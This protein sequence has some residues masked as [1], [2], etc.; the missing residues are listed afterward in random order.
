MAGNLLQPIGQ[1][2]VRKKKLPARF[3]RLTRVATVV[4]APTAA[5][6]AKALAATSWPIGLWP[7]LVDGQSAATEFSPVQGCRCLIG[8]T[9]IRHFYKGEAARAAGFP[10]RHQADFFHCAV[11]LENGSQLGFGRAVGQITNVKVLHCISSLSKSS[12]VTSARKSR[13]AV[14]VSIKSTFFLLTVLGIGE[15]SGE[16]NI[17]R[18]TRA[19]L[20]VRRWF[21]RPLTCVAF[22]R[23]AA[24]L[25]FASGERSSACARD[26]IWIYRHSVLT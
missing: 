16:G 14:E 6:T 13:F 8:F 11:R 1:T 24:V 22:P 25:G 2:F 3:A 20:S 9:G 17:A 26:E 5:P 19:P 10:V 21:E 23:A 4:V 12:R 7:G 15:K 18:F